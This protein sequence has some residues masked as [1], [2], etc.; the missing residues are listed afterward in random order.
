MKLIAWMLVALTVSCGA[1]DGDKGKPTPPPEQPKPEIPDGSVVKT[2][3]CVYSETYES[4]ATQDMEYNVLKYKGEMSAATLKRVYTNGDYTLTRY[5]SAY[6]SSQAEESVTAYLNDDV[7][8]V[9]L[10]GDE[11]QFTR[12]STS[13]TEG[14]NCEVK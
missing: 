1:F 9:K 13:K 6:Y 4:G 11:A 10:A 3:F 2:Y 7:Y 8:S 14:V 12:V 5:A